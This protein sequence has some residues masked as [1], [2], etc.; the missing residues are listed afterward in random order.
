MPGLVVLCLF[1]GCKRNSSNAKSGSGATD[2]ANSANM[3]SQPLVRSQATDS[4]HLFEIVPASES[5]VDFVHLWKPKDQYQALML[6]TGFTGGGVCIGDYDGDGLPDL[7]LT[8]PHGGGRLFRNLG[9][10]KFE[11]VTNLHY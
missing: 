5:G 11:D 10:F 7:Y 2:L 3:S 4:E 9:D 8:R 1:V 6:K